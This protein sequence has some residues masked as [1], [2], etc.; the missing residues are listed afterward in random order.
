MPLNV[1]KCPKVFPPWHPLQDLVSSA[2]WASRV[3]YWTRLIGIRRIPVIHPLESIANQVVQP[4]WGR[5]IATNW[6]QRP[7]EAQHFLFLRMSWVRSS[8]FKQPSI[9]GI[10]MTIAIGAIAGRIFPL[11][12]SRQVK[13]QLRQLSK[14]QAIVLG[15]LPTHASGHVIGS[16]SIPPNRVEVIVPL[17]GM[18]RQRISLHIHIKVPIS[19]LVL[20]N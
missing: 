1:G 9:C 4:K 6:I 3:I 18:R 7:V 17:R 19:D 10:R 15:L 2:I 8:L 5:G 11:G 13:W 12:F 14:P 16:P 20:L